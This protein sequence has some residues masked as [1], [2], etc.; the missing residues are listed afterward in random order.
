[1]TNMRIE[2]DDEFDD[3]EDEEYEWE[4]DEDSDDIAY[5]I[6]SG[7]ESKVE[8]ELNILSQEGWTIDEMSAFDSNNGTR[9]VLVMSIVAENSFQAEIYRANSLLY[10]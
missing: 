3:E 9:I 7:S 10:P 5:K 1:M 4:D 2:D 6:L 8:R